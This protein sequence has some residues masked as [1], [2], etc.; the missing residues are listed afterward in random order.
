MW[1]YGCCF[2]G[3]TFFSS[4]CEAL[5]SILNIYCVWARFW[6]HCARLRIFWVIRKI[7][8]I[9]C[10]GGQRPLGPERSDYMRFLA[11]WISLAKAILLH[12]ISLFVEIY[13]LFVLY[14]VF[15]NVVKTT[16][17]RLERNPASV[18]NFLQRN[19][20]NMTDGIDR[21]KERKCSKINEP[22]PAAEENA[23]CA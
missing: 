17:G 23:T 14:N 8:F 21:T 22:L 16:N 9:K 10:A 5:S 18:R 4:L 12:L 1:I 15:L 6:N 20:S 3:Y 11:S 13:Y 7:R 2:L 19:G